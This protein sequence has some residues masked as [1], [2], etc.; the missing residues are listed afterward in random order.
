VH[1]IGSK[2]SPNNLRFGGGV[3]GVDGYLYC[4]PLYA[5]QVL[6][7]DTIA[8]SKHKREQ[9]QQQHREH[10]SKKFNSRTAS[11]GGGG[12]G[13]SSSTSSTSSSST[14][15]TSSGNSN[16]T[17]TTNI[18]AGHPELVT[19]RTAPIKPSIKDKT[20]THSN[21]LRQQSSVVI[22]AEEEEEHDAIYSPTITWQKP[23]EAIY[24]V[25]MDKQKY[26]EKELMKTG[27]MGGRRASDASSTS[28]SPYSSAAVSTTTTMPPIS[29]DTNNKKKR[30]K[31]DNKNKNKKSQ[32]N[33][34]D[35]EKAEDEEN[36]DD[37][38]DDEDFNEDGIVRSMS[39][40]EWEVI[41]ISS[42][43]SEEQEIH[44]KPFTPR[45][46]VRAIVA[47]VHW[48]KFAIHKARLRQ[49]YSASDHVIGNKDKL[50]RNLLIQEP[51]VWCYGLTLENS[52]I[53]EDLCD[54]LAVFSETE[55]YGLAAWLFCIFDFLNV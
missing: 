32:D 21:T 31:N 23:P 43:A 54:W 36:E 1:R 29:L 20:H 26:K 46:A 41:G 33:K 45:M 16:T 40:Q 48:R 2:L 38:D 15:S 55:V 9:H 10:L 19:S 11:G 44:Q 27:G 50:M 3:V 52:S 42:G 30:N 14:S 37:D 24:N 53:P 28:Y 7:L 47:Y 18:A 12:G 5:N 25:Y 35:S 39:G 49:G 34:K 6:R 13:G 17:N 22:V 4:S 51:D 8:L